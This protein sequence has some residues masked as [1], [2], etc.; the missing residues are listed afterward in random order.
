VAKTFHRISISVFFDFLVLR[1]VFSCFGAATLAILSEMETSNCLWVA[2]SCMVCG[3]SGFK[4]LM[5]KKGAFGF[6]W[7]LLLCLDRLYWFTQ[8]HPEAV[9]GTST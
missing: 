3:F 4:L 9:V 7:K 6:F 8:E 2:L 5:K 1:S